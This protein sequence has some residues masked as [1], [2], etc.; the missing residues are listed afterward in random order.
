MKRYTRRH[1]VQRAGAVTATIGFAAGCRHVKVAGRGGVSREDVERLRVT[2][3]GRLILP[4][5]PSY[6]SARRVFYWN[7]TTERTPQIVVQCSCEEDV[8][9][10]V[11]FAQRHKL[12]IAVRAGGHS[13]LGWGCSDGVVIDLSG[14][15][16]VA[17]DPTRRVARV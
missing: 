8:L 9:R 3:K 13:H 14:M 1:F 11:E 12:E 5:D 7:A 15:K 2:I 4:G 6:E 17:I 16:E 10:G